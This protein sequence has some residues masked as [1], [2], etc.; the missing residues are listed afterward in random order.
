[1]CGRV[2][3]TSEAQAI[4]AAIGDGLVLMEE[5]APLL[6]TRY[7]LSPSQEMLCARR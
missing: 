4:A 7:N 5:V 3:L 1:M 2:T 6:E